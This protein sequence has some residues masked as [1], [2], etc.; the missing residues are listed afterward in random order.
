VEHFLERYNRENGKHV[1]RVHADALRRMLAYPWPGNVRE[2]ENV[3]E[4]GVVLS[5]GEE[6]GVDL[7]PLE[8]QDN[9]SL[10]EVAVLPEGASFYDAVARYERQLIETALVRSGRVQK[11]AAAL[12]GLKPTTLSEMIKRLG[13]AV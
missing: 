4:R 6:F 8:I 3:V 10:P 2:L 12:L 13:I 1:Q 11:Q 5:Q 7:L 9:V